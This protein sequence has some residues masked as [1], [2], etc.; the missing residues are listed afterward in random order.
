M[1][2]DDERNRWCSSSTIAA[3]EARFPGPQ[4]GCNT[5]YPLTL[6]PQVQHPNTFDTTTIA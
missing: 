5:N 2:H 1:T 6:K 3:N 4:G